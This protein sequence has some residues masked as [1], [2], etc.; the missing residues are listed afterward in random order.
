MFVKLNFKCRILDSF[1]AKFYLLLIQFVTVQLIDC[2]CNEFFSPKIIISL[3]VENTIKQILITIV[4]IWFKYFF[5]FW[6]K[7]LID[8]R[9]GKHEFCTEFLSTDCIVVRYF[10]RKTHTFHTHGLKKNRECRRVCVRYLE[11]FVLT[12]DNFP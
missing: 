7:Y 12:F 8:N 4:I 11:N 1:K 3:Y 5:F 2:L 10:L 6:I 9:S